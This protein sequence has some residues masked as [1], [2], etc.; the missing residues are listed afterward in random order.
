M[1]SNDARRRPSAQKIL[2]FVRQL[3]A[4]KVGL[5][6]RV[7]CVCSKNAVF[8]EEMDTYILCA[9]VKLF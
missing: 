9:S 7:L 2:E 3:R 5:P 1:L 4:K 8:T 6:L